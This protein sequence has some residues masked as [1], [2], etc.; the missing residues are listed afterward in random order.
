MKRSILIVDDDEGLA[1]MVS[2]NLIKDGYDVTVETNGMR[3]LEVAI[4]TKPD[5]V[6]LDVMMPELNG[7]EVCQQLRED[8][9]TATLPILMLTA[10]QQEADKVT[11]LDSGADDYLPKPFKYRELLARVRAIL[12]RAEFDPATPKRLMVT[13]SQLVAGPIEI[14]LAGQRVTCRGKQVILQ[15]KEYMLLVY[16]VRHQG[17]VLS[18]D[19]LLQ[20]VWGDNFEGGMRTV[21][22]HIRWLREKLEEDPGSPKLIETVLKVG[23]CF[24]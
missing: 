18:R 1:E 10:R 21:D 2:Y 24:R 23:Y 15:P 16:L 20:D 14:D 17:M 22:V 13:P 5:L 19:Q 12:R 3:G 11:G 6:I 8:E 7:F 4:R 9:Q